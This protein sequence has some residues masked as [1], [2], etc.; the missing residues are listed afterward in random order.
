MKASPGLTSQARTNARK[1]TGGTYLK[2]AIFILTRRPLFSKASLRL[3]TS[4]DSFCPP[5]TSSLLLSPPILL[6]ALLVAQLGVV[7]IVAD[8]IPFHFFIDWL[9]ETRVRFLAL[10]AFAKPRLIHFL[11]T[12]S[13]GVYYVDAHWFSATRNIIHLL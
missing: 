11:V 13:V 12:A 4:S 1:T 6:H 7:A 9:A 3:L 2:S 8:A 5:S 10:V